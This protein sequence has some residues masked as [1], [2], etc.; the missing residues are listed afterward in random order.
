MTGRSE[1]SIQNEALIAASALPD[2]FVWRNNTGQGWVGKEVPTVP[3]QFVKIEPGM[4]VLKDA[5]RVKFGLPGSG[6]ILGTVGGV[7]VA[8][9]AKTST[10]CQSDQQVLFQRA[11]ERAGGLYILFR[12]P[13]EFVN[14]IVRRLGVR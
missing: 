4:V 2:S 14:G 7:A 13:E 5:R 11:W 1:K 12:S 9:E 6:D 10:G 3:G 8:G